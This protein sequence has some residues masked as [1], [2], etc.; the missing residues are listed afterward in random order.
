MTS[1]RTDPLADERLLAKAQVLAIVPVVEMTLWRWVRAGKFPAP[2]LVG[3]SNLW[4]WSELKPFL[5]SRPRGWLH[6]SRPTSGAVGQRQAARK[7]REAHR[8][9]RVAK[10]AANAAAGA[11]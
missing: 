9:R 10:A 5:A 1:E 4:R 8:A 6:A 7:K 2:I 3:G 11:T